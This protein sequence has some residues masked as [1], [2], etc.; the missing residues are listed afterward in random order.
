MKLT[1]FFT[2]L[3][4]LTASGPLWSSQIQAGKDCVM[5]EGK[6]P[7]ISNEPAVIS[8]KEMDFI[9]ACYGSPT[10][11]EEFRSVIIMRYGSMERF[12]EA[13]NQIKCQ[14]R[15]VI[16]LEVV[17]SEGNYRTDWIEGDLNGIAALPEAQRL[18]IINRTYKM[19]GRG[20]TIMDRINRIL[21]ELEEDNLLPDHIQ[22]VRSYHEALTKM[23]AK[24]YKDL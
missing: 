3:F 9:C 11:L 24:A 18:A 6:L 15:D 4:I 22:R 17:I 20:Q 19:A 13:Y 12:Y 8:A 21:R 5:C 7:D 23:G 16:P 10:I 14:P 1:S 2:C